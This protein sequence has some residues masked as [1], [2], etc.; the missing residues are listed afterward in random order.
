[1]DA[2]ATWPRP[3]ASRRASSPDDWQGQRPQTGE[4]PSRMMKRPELDFA[5][6]T[7]SGNWRER[8]PLIGHSRPDAPADPGSAR[9]LRLP[10][11]DRT[12]SEHLR[13]LCCG[14]HRRGRAGSGLRDAG[15]RAQTGPRERPEVLAVAAAYRAADPPVYLRRPRRAAQSQFSPAQPRGAQWSAI[16]RRLSDKMH[17]LFNLK[18]H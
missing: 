2:L 7:I 11:P 9:Y 14:H 18:C 10:A 16:C 13:R 17:Q 6:A 5:L 3:L 12:C 4:S 1:M 8:V 15:L